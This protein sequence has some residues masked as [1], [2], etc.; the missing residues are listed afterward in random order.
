MYK[1]KKIFIK[2]V[3]RRKLFSSFDL[4]SPGAGFFPIVTHKLL[5]IFVPIF[6]FVLEVYDK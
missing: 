1:D 6:D 2:F 3:K 5:R 4:W